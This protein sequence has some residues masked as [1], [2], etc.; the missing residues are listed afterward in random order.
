VIRP[1]RVGLLLAA[2]VCVSGG[3]ATAFAPALSAQ[4]TTRHAPDTASS[5]LPSEQDYS[6]KRQATM[7]D[8]KTA[9]H[10][11]AELRTER[12]ELE[13]RVDSVAVKA[14]QKRA[15]ELLL[16]HETTALR[17]LDSMLTSSQEILLAQRDR[18]LSLGEA[19]RRRA[20]AELV[21]VVR[22][23]SGTGSQHVE[24]LTVQVDS[25]P[26]A[27]RRYS[28]A[29]NDALSA[30]AVDEVY[31]S[32]VL[33]STHAVTLTMS[34]NGSSQTKAVSVDVPTGAITYVQ[35]TVHAGQLALSTWINRS[36][37]Q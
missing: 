12:I 8:I 10:K 11:L 33:P 9:Q 26:A 6:S 4:D 17:S 37:P 32:N 19:V 5:T 29:A 1:R 7:S 34:L 25:A 23:D 18:F 2:F 35:F 36:G 22:V 21:V 24:G 16:S 31:H 13:S 27:E 20:D 30:G 3:A 14:T 28:D 15:S